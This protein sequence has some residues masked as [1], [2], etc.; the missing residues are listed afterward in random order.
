[1]TLSSDS[2]R[3]IP[4]FSPAV[5]NWTFQNPQVSND[6]CHS[7][8]AETSNNGFLLRRE[9][10]AVHNPPQHIW[11]TVVER[12]RIGPLHER[13]RTLSWFTTSIFVCMSY[14]YSAAFGLCSWQPNTDDGVTK[15]YWR[16]TNR[17]SSIVLQYSTS[18]GVKSRDTRLGTCRSVLQSTPEQYA[19]STA[20]TSPRPFS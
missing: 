13:T 2:A 7:I 3:L 18:I 20:P 1:M 10:F 12:A 16:M 9:T 5:F 14:I 8:A 17:R 4:P 19:Y 6:W 11:W 15:Q